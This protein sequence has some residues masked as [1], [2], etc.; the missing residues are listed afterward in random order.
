MSILQI[1]CNCLSA[2]IGQRWLERNA[3]IYKEEN[4]APS[5]LSRFLPT[6]LL[7]QGIFLKYLG[8]HTNT[9]AHQH[10]LHLLSTNSPM[11]LRI[12]CVQFSP[13]LGMLD[14]NVAKIRALTNNISRDIDLLVLPEL[15][16][17]GYN[18]KNSSQI[19]PFLENAGTGLSHRIAKELSAKFGCT[20]VIGYPES[21]NG[22]IYNSALV[23]GQDGTV[24]SNY[25]KTH[26]YETDE[27][28]GCS[29][30]PNASFPS[31]PLRLGTHTFTTNIGICMDLNPK[32]FTASFLKFEFSRKCW[33]NDASLVIVPMAWLST[34]SPNIQET[35]TPAEKQAKAEEFAKLLKTGFPKG[36]TP[37]QELIN[38][39]I[40]RFYPFLG[41]NENEPKLLNHKTTV[42]LC[43]RVGLED[44]V[45][46]G[47]LTSVLQFDPLKSVGQN[48]AEWSNESVQVL[49]SAGRAS[50]EVLYC[51]V[52]V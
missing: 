35:L 13:L 23:V 22:S 6:T 39:W 34:E 37:S 41:H 33:K 11:K 1:N 10:H 31:F 38:Y 40:I 17:T 52:D 25:R 3:K 21:F 9:E 16:V 43:N 12:A 51:E 50:E 48:D 44:D 20:T 32:H 36:T 7:V 15:A 29:E 19:G 47:G 26:L 18:F 2:Q 42:I 28:W 46:Y 49:A 5:L 14:A 45:L 8:R 24:L 27:V 4:C 30:N